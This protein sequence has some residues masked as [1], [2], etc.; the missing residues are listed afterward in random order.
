MAQPAP[1]LTETDEQQAEMKQALNTAVNAVQVAYGVAN[2]TPPYHSYV[3]QL[4][5]I[6]QELIHLNRMA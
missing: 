1:T 3:E 5:K 6:V 2:R 4:A